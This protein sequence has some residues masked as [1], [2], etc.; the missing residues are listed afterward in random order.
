MTGQ[1]QSFESLLSSLS[2]ISTMDT[3][4]GALQAVAGYYGLQ[5]YYDYFESVREKAMDDDCFLSE[6]DIQ[7]IIAKQNEMIEQIRKINPDQADEI[8]VALI[9]L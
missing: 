1:K 9:N 5:K 8:E 4:Q 7:D 6:E 2:L 3:G